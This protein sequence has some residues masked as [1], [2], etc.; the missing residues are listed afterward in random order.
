MAKEYT[1]EPFGETTE[2]GA[3]T[4]NSFQFTGRENDGTGLFY[5]R[6]R[7]YSPQ[8]HRFTSEDPVLHAGEPRVPFLLPE[9]IYDP[10]KLHPYAYTGNNPINYTDATGLQFYPPIPLVGPLPPLP[11]PTMPSC[12]PSEE[13]CSQYPK[14]SLLY[15]VCINTPDR[16]WSNCVRKCLRD[17]YLECTNLGCIIKDHIRCWT[18]CPFVEG[19]NSPIA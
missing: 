4:T 13:S 5:Y 10:P 3:D 1:Y 12:S 18:I 8:L 14:D 11:T 15:S 6:A 9:L 16:P 2:V 17:A 7:Y 19:A